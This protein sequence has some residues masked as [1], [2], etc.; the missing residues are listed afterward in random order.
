[1]PYQVIESK[2]ASG[3]QA[4]CSIACVNVMMSIW[5]RPALPDVQCFVN[6]WKQQITAPLVTYLEA[7]HPQEEHDELQ[8]V[9]PHLP[10]QDKNRE[11]FI[12]DIQQLSALFRQRTGCLR[13]QAQL[14]WVTQLLCP[15]FHCDANTYRMLC[16]YTGE[17]TLWTPW[18][19]VKWEN[20]RLPQ[21]L[22]H[23]ENIFQS[24]AFEVLL[25]KGSAHPDTDQH[26]QFHRSPEASLRSPRLILKVDVSR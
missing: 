24:Q 6:Q 5:K 25:M 7:Y 18:E 17:G 26:G 9:V 4:L 1:M 21:N 20:T 12:A 16:T 8:H 19:N 22:I 2:H 15:R 14:Q 3:Q 11:R 23:P 13:A 10:G